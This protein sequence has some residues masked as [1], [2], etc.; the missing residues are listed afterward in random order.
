MMLICNTD[1][2]SKLFMIVILQFIESTA[3]T[4]PVVD[5][6]IKMLKV[7]VGN[8]FLFANNDIFLNL[9]ISA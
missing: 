1:S 6:N 8:S 7:D 2:H 9:M 4:T 5:W 3:I